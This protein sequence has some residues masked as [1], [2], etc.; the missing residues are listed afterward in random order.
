VAPERRVRRLTRCRGMQEGENLLLML[1]MASLS[2]TTSDLAPARNGRRGGV[3]GG[4]ASPPPSAGGASGEAMRAGSR[5]GHST[6]RHLTAKGA[7]KDLGATGQDYPVGLVSNSPA[8]DALFGPPF[9]YARTTA[10]SGPGTVLSASE[11]VVW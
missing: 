7:S 6:Q 4:V 5:G 8:F 1:L 11:T 2:D 3:G 9:I 10:A